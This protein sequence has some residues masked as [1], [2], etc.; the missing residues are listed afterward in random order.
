VNHFLQVEIAHA[1]VT[2]LH[3]A[4]C[5]LARQLL[6]GIFNGWMARHRDKGD[7]DAIYILK[8]LR[9]WESMEVSL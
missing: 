2:T 4:E 7:W 6:L 8:K 9:Y 3:H 5:H 1:A